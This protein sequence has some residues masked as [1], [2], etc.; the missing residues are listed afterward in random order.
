MIVICKVRALRKNVNRIKL[1]SSNRYT[2]NSSGKDILN[3]VF[4]LHQY[5]SN[6]R[7]TKT[8]AE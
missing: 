5:N 8:V 7:R 2:L 1:L 3:F 4:R 6:F